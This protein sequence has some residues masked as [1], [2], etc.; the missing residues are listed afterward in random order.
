MREGGR[1]Y[2]RIESMS[3]PGRALNWQVEWSKS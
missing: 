2:V 3:D 1:G